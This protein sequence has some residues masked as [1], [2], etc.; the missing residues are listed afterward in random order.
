V[1]F[2][3]NRRSRA[4]GSSSTPRLP[5][6]AIVSIAAP[7]AP[8]DQGEE[9]DTPPFFAEKDGIKKDEI[10]AGT[11]HTLRHHYNGELRLTDVSEMFV[12]MRDHV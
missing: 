5:S 7:F 1:T 3:C 9:P 11:L 8:L 6:A 2:F 10:A 12:Q 4:E